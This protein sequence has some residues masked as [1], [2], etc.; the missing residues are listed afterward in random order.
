[1]LRTRVAALVLFSLVLSVATGGCSQ[2]DQ[3]ELG[4]VSGTVKWN[5]EPL[6]GVIVMFKPENGRPGSAETDTQGNYELFYKAGVKGTK[7]G[8]NT[9]SLTWP[10]GFDG[11]VIPEK[12]AGR[13]ELKLDVKAGANKYDIEIQGEKQQP[14]PGSRPPV[15]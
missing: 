12:Y 13:S 11:P 8:P 2:G 14:K 15:D 3:P 7:L 5:G 6:A 1:M 9:V 4:E 10:T